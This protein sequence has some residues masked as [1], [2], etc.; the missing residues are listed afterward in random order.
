M[1]FPKPNQSRERL[2][3]HVLPAPDSSTNFALI[4][5]HMK[6]G[7]SSA[8]CIDVLDRQ[9]GIRPV[10]LLVPLRFTDY[11]LEK[12]RR[13][14]EPHSLCELPSS[15][16]QIAAELSGLTAREL[17]ALIQDRD[18]EFWDYPPFES[19]V[20]AYSLFDAP[21]LARRPGWFLG[22]PKAPP[23]ILALAPQISQA[24]P[25]LDRS[26]TGVWRF[27][28]DND[29]VKAVS[30][31]IGAH[32]DLGSFQSI[33]GIGHLGTALAISVAFHNRD[34]FTGALMSHFGSQGLVP[35]PSTLRNQKTLALTMRLDTGV[36]AVDAF[37]RIT[38]ADGTLHSIVSVFPPD[39]SPSGRSAFYR[40]SLY[41][42]GEAGVRIES[43]L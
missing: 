35:R 34:S 8:T 38:Q 6:S 40:S 2:G 32:M 33:L 15:A 16:P 17:T 7:T 4:D 11:W 27:F 22:R 1:G 20:R 31:A 37:H 18:S 42:L 21:G 25:W 28:T 23:A 36:Y 13:G 5:S 24:F 19:H 3:P 12:S 14:V 9:H 26:D 10:S 30:H 39:D 41:R 29:L 43:V